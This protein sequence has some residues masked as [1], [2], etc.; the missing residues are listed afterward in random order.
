MDV[1]E[2]YSSL[3]QGVVDGQENPLSEI[4]NQRFYEVQ[5][6]ISLTEHVYTPMLFSCGGQTWEDLPRSRRTSS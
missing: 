5:K 1:S 3:Q 4:V 2:L 6:F